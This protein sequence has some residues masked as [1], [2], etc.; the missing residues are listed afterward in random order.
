MTNIGSILSGVASN[1]YGVIAGLVVLMVVFFILRKKILAFFQGIQDSKNKNEV[2][3]EKQ[4]V[5][6]EVQKN[7]DESDKLKQIEGR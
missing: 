6:S 7:Q 1:P 5:E 2:I 4:S 3:D